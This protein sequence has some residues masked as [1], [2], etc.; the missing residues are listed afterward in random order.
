MHSCNVVVYSM[1]LG[2]ARPT[3]RASARAPL[4]CPRIVLYCIEASGG[5]AALH[6][7]S[8]AAPPPTQPPTTRQVYVTSESDVMDC[9]GCGN[10]NRM[11][12]STLMNAQS[13]RSHALLSLTLRQKFADGSVRT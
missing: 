9:L 4:H 13:S 11:V 1:V 10:A 12:G 7:R 8:H 3:A 2:H 6:E 5:A